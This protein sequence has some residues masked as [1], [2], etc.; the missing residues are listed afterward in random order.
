MGNLQE[1]T[2]K[3]KRSRTPEYSF[4]PPKSRSLVHSHKFSEQKSLKKSFE[5]L[6]KVVAVV[7]SLS[8][9]TLERRAGCS[10]FSSIYVYSLTVS[11]CD[12]KDGI[13]GGR[14]LVEQYLET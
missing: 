3:R 11:L 10:C 1:F 6:G 9:C 8:G 4:L 14:T 2:I 7:L 13:S 12:Q 5:K